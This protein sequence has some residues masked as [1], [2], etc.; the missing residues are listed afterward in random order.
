MKTSSSL[1]LSLQ[2]TH[3]SSPLLHPFLTPSFSPTSYLNSHLPPPPSTSIPQTQQSPKSPTIALS[4]L[5]TQANSQITTLSTLTSRLSSTLTTL[6]DDILRCSSRLTYEIEVL[7]QEADALAATLTA[8]KSGSEIDAAIRVFLPNGIVTKPHDEDGDGT[9]IP[10]LSPANPQVPPTAPQQQQQPTPQERGEDE[11][12]LSHLHTLLAVRTHLQATTK[13]FSLALSWPMPPSLLPSSTTTSLI[14]IASPTSESATQEQESKGQ[15]ALAR[16]R[17]E[18]EE[19][20]FSEGVE[21][22]E[23]GIE[24]ARDKVAELKECVGVWKGTSEEKA[25]GK[26]VGELEGWVEEVAAAKR[27]EGIVESAG[28]GGGKGMGTRG[29]GAVVEGGVPARTGSGAGFLRRL[30]EEIYME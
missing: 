16:M 29:G 8:E 9:T 14:T 21:G 10:P 12:P 22:E 30:R 17:R 18:V 28:E 23:R 7:R 2:S 1:S 19:L 4:T 11:L 24:K 13:L 15:E 6:T 26:W 5:T 27:R 3:L 20:A 25:R